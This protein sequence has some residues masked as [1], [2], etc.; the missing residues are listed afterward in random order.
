MTNRTKVAIFFGGKSYEHD[1]SILT[2]LQAIQVLDITKYEAVPV[3]IDT[4]GNWWSGKQLLNLKNYPITDD[5]YKNLYNI[6]IN[7]GKKNS[8]PTL[9]INNSKL[10]CKKTIEFDIALFALHG[11][12]GETGAIQG[13]MEMANIPYTGANVLSSAIYMDKIKT[14]DICRKL[15]IKVLDETIIKKP[16]NETFID[17]NEITKNLKITY[18]VC[19]K[20]VNLGSS[21][22]VYKATNKDELNS[23]I[24]SIFKIDTEIIIEPF[25]ENLKEY[26]IAVILNKDDKIIT[27]AIETPTNK[28]DFLTFS[29]K[30]LSKKGAK[31]TTMKLALPDTKT[32]ESRREFNPSLTKEQETFIKDSVVKL[33]D[34]MNATGNPRIDF[35]S[36]AKTGELWLN[37]VNPIPGSFA[38]YLWEKSKYK[39]NYTE[40]ISLIIENGLK[41]F[42][43]KTKSINLI[44]SNSKIF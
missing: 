7:T 12:F 34:Y 4:N 13:L 5:T 26:N 28:N 40:L 19:L 15:N 38:F 35:L 1:V 44:N 18:P 10:F 37:E 33:F 39:L 32:L 27:S 25:V 23:A 11:D 2:G 36:N 29:D 22:G 42:K 43:N 9:Y 41:N 8:K 31:K 6:S 24:L 16:K 21:V 20:P 30:Y 14:K 3:Y 17:I